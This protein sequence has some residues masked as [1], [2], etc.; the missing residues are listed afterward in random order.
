[1]LAVL[2]QS[3]QFLL[4]ILVAYLFKKADILKSTDGVI[5]QKIILNL[6]LP[7]TIIVGFN[8]VTVEPILFIM[9]TLGLMTNILLSAAGG[10]LW[11]KKEPADQS[12]MMF[13]QAGYRS[14][15]LPSLLFR[16]FS[17]PPSLISAVSIWATP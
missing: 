13:S 4:V 16:V 2:L 15:T 14:A 10:Y 17:R 7:A 5:L 1:M 11:R 12:L 8:G 3:L 6:T 9:I